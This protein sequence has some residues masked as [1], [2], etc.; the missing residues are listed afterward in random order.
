M[1]EYLDIEPVIR[2]RKKSRKIAFLMNNTLIRESK[3][4]K[5]F[6]KKRNREAVKQYF[7]E[8]YV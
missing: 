8:Y 6:S 1:F 5:Y 4:K 7:W 3:R 2:I